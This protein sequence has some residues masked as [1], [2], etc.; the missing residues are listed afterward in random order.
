MMLLRGVVILLTVNEVRARLYDIDESL[1]RIFFN[2]FRNYSIQED[3]RKRLAQFSK[4]S[5][6]NSLEGT[7]SSFSVGRYDELLSEDRWLHNMLQC[8]A[9]SERLK[10]QSAFCYGYDSSLV[11]SSA[12]VLGV[13]IP[14]NCIHDRFQLL[15]EWG[16]LSVNQSVMG[17]AS[18]MNSRRERPWYFSGAP[19]MQVTIVVALLLLTF[20]ATLLDRNLSAK[21]R[22]CPASTSTATQ[23]LLS[24]SLPRNLHKL[25]EFPKN[26]I[27]TVTCMFG[28]RVISMIWTLIGHCFAWIQAYV[29]N[30][31]DLKNDLSNGFFNVTIT[32]FTLSVDTFFVLSATLTS[33]SYFQKQ[34]KQAEGFRPYQTWWEW[35]AE[36]LKFYRHRII[37]LWPAYLY[38]LSTVTFLFSAVH[39]HP[40]WEPSD[41]AVQCR[42]HGWQNVLF[43]N[44]LFGNQCMG[45]TWYISTEFLFYLI[46]PIFL[47]SLNKS[48]WL[49]CALSLTTIIFS[50]LLMSLLIIQ[51]DYPPSP[52]PYNQ[53]SIFKGVFMQHIDAYYIKP[54]YRIGPYIVGIILGYM[55]ADMQKWKRRRIT[56]RVELQWLLWSVCVVFGFVSLYGFYPVM[57]GWNWRWY[58]VIY[59]GVHRTVWA[60][61]VAVLIYMCHTDQGGFLNAILSARVFLPLSTLCYS[62]YLIHLVM[63]FAVFLLVPFPI[64]YTGKLPIL[65]F[66]LAQLALSFFS[67]LFITM[68]SEFPVLNIEKVLLQWSSERAQNNALKAYPL[69]LN[70]KN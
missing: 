63:V 55:L 47:I 12:V 18:C 21:Q 20:I 39:W 50:S 16:L 11:A 28:V 65:I 8:F 9:S 25:I 53:P 33:Y 26:P 54:Q 42:L 68:L 49:G 46:S 15:E 7:L 1:P 32:N 2:R 3:C 6:G 60:C 36:W 43:V 13:C 66:C 45:W 30:V 34:L 23:L 67:A 62:V 57:Q 61:A 40:M 27:S 19:M 24:F 58:Y 17:Y 44:S 22:S 14:S 64:T 52:I 59:G 69:I 31:Q 5:G 41:P 38:A 35:L 10:E 37:R 48:L 51:H 56:D 4:L 70:N 29:S